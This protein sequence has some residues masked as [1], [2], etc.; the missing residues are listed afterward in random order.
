MGLFSFLKSSKEDTL[1][2]DWCGQKME[3]AVYTKCVGD[4]IFNFCSESCKKDFR[5]S[6]K[7]NSSKSCSACALRR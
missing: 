4:K 2:C 1:K 7:G 6:N 5:K 3:A